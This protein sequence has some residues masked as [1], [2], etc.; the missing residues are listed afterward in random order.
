MWFLRKVNPKMI[1]T[2]LML[3]ASEYDKETSEIMIQSMK[4]A[5]ESFSNKTLEEEELEAT[6]KDILDKILE[7]KDLILAQQKYKHFFGL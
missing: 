5:E 4:N 6:T 2:Q 3:Q 1:V 7:E